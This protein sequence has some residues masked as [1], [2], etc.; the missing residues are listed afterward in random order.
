ME[1]ITT[2]KK[3]TNFNKLRLNIGDLWNLRKDTTLERIIKFVAKD[4]DWE[5]E[6]LLD[7]FNFNNVAF[8]NML[9]DVEQIELSNA[10]KRFSSKP[11]NKVYKFTYYQ[12]D[13]TEHE[14]YSVAN[15]NIPFNY[16]KKY[17]R[18]SDIADYYVVL[19]LSYIWGLF[20]LLDMVLTFSKEYDFTDERFKDISVFK[21]SYEKN[22]IEYLTE[23]A[24]ETEF[25]LFS[26]RHKGQYNSN[27]RDKYLKIVKARELL[28]DAIIIM[29]TNDRNVYLL[30]KYNTTSNNDYAKSFETKKSIPN[31]I[32]NVMNKTSFL[33]DFSYVELDQEV[34]LQKFSLIEKE[35]LKLKEII[36]YPFASAPNLRFRKLGQHKALGLYYPTFNCICIDINSPSSFVHELSHFL[37]Y[38]ATDTNLSLSYNFYPIINKYSACIRKYI[39]NNENETSKYLKNKLDYFL[40]PTEIFARMAEIYWINKGIKSS[41]LKTKEELNIAGGYPE[42]S[43][44]FLN[45]VNEFFDNLFASLTPLKTIQHKKN[46]QNKKSDTINDTSHAICEIQSN[47]EINNAGQCYFKF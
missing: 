29:K 26:V 20:K 8:N 38:T 2:L 5:K 3:K 10:F 31:N 25:T 23:F 18:H 28:V 33:Q 37:D 32:L 19:N 36:K 34:D 27:A 22:D 40:T 21:Q 4:F 43:D 45:M 35:W 24:Q 41:L 11:D 47:I 16:R 44:N 12:Q 1:R 46:I 30:N 13:D 42:M 17:F 9:E 6:N 39:S 14:V 15:E 7:N